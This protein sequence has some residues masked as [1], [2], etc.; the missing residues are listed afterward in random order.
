MIALQERL[1]TFEEFLEWLPENDRRYEL[2]EGAIAEV[3]P[4]GPHAKVA[5]FI[6]AKLFEQIIRQQKP[7][8]IPLPVAFIKPDAERAGYQP[9]ILIL[10][11]EKIN[12]DPLWNSSSTISL[13]ESAKLVV[14]VVSTNW[15]DDYLTKLRDYESMGIPEYWIVDYRA[16]GA[17]RY[18]GSP[19]QPTLSVYRLFDGEYQVE[20]FRG[21]DRIVSPTFPALEL[22]ANQVFTAGEF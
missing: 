19:K 2:I 6:G 18:T 14:E 12:A 3:K 7:W 15:K 4:T 16:L 9:D 22:T 17:T 8:F 10:D 11:N 5:G 21:G 1:L 13:G 20:Q